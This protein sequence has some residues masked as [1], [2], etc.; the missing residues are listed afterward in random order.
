MAGT[1]MVGMVGKEVA[2]RDD[3]QKYIEK[4]GWKI[5]HNGQSRIAPGARLE[6]IKFVNNKLNIPGAVEKK[7]SIPGKEMLDRI[8]AMGADLN[9]DDALWLLR[10]QEQIPEDWRQYYLVT[11][12]VCED[13]GGDLAVLYLYW[14]VGQWNWNFDYVHGDFN[15]NDRAV[16][17]VN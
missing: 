4:N 10:N 2:I 11:A 17:S 9:K 6:L 13:S 1:L 5:V 15:G 16:L 7:S 8:V 14:S 12:F 3:I